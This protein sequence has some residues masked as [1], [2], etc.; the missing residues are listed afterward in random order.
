MGRKK[1]RGYTRRSAL[2]WERL[3]SEQAGSGVSQRAFCNRRGLSHSS[4]YHWKRRLGEAVNGK[5][6][7]EAGFI[8]LAVEPKEALQWEVELTLSPGVVLRVRRN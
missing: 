6:E 2:E 4:F 3:L 7:S 5:E 1:D 8:E